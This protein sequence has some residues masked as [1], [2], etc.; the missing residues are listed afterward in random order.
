MG[1]LESYR[2]MAPKIRA[3]VLLAEYRCGK[4]CLLLH[5]WSTPDGRNYYQPPYRL[6]PEVAEAETVESARLKR[7]LDG[8][9]KW[10]D[11]A[12]SFD[13]LI[14]AAEG[15]TPGTIGL[16]LTCDHIREI[17]SVESIATD[18]APARPG[19]PAKILLPRNP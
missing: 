19:V 5:I 12:G 3:Q 17:I 4:R 13:E 18:V 9:R 11:R 2:D 7:T 6:S 1:P 15:L 16:T 14:D 8:Y 10:Q